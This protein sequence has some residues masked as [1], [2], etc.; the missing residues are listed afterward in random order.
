[1]LDRAYGA[2]R[3]GDVVS[4]QVSGGALLR[5]TKRRISRDDHSKEAA[6]GRCC[7]GVPDLCIPEWRC[8]VELKRKV[9]GKLSDE[10]KRVIAYLEGIG[11]T[12]IVGYGA[13]DASRKIMDFVK[14]KSL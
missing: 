11:D 4:G 5:Y 7:P 3:V 8:W 6:R 1:M 2:A 10:Q 12:V 13:E 14:F 9:G